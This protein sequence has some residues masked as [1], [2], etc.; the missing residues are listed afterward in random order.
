MNYLNTNPE[1][2]QRLLTSKDEAFIKT[3]NTDLRSSPS[4]NL[5][6]VL[7][8]IITKDKLRGI[9]DAFFLLSSHISC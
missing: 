7:K 6:G 1:K 9:M 5:W 2:S 4:K 8:Y 3:D